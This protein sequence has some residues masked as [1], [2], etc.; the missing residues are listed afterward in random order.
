LSG[1]LTF[2]TEGGATSACPAK[3]GRSVAQRQLTRWCHAESY[4]TQLEVKRSVYLIE[5]MKKRKNNLSI[6]K[7]LLE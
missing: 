2:L 1:K 7:T 5:N 6:L 3:P 4:Q